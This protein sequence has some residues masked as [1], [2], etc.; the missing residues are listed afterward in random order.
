MTESMTYW[1][2]GGPP[3][4]KLTTRSRKLAHKGARFLVGGDAGGGGT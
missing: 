2:G 3:T 4:R 1:S